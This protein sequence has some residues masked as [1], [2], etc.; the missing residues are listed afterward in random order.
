MI[1]RACESR[2][3]EVNGRICCLIDSMS[4]RK[5]VLFLGD[6]TFAFVPHD[7][8]KEYMATDCKNIRRKIKSAMGGK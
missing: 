1:E 3:Y 6:L 8:A 7:E 4:S 5:R 2:L